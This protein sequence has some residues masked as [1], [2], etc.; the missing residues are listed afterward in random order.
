MINPQAHPSLPSPKPQPLTP[1]LLLHRSCLPLAYLDPIGGGQDQSGSRLFTANIGILEKDVPEDAS[2]PPRVLIAQST[3]DDKL[4]AVERVQIGIYALCG[5]NT[6]VTLK[7]L[8]RLQGTAGDEHRIMKQ[9][10]LMQTQRAEEEWWSSAAVKPQREVETGVGNL[11]NATRTGEFALCLQRPIQ[12][13]P[14]ESQIMKQTPSTVAT[15]INTALEA[16]ADEVSQ[17]PQEVFNMIRSQYQEA[18]YASKVST[19]HCTPVSY[20]TNPTE[21]I[22][23]V[24]CKRTTFSSTSCFPFS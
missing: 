21:D 14:P 23:G 3:V 12:N 8:E 13:S 15:G 10:Y 5:L 19:L 18:L 1:T 20:I 11:T 4:W 22:F 6:W 16:M 2:S 7:M 24:L 9:H 17:G